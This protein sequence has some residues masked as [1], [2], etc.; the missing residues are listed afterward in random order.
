MNDYQRMIRN[1]HEEL[2]IP[3]EFA[4]TCKIPMQVEATDLVSI[5][6]DV[7]GRE[8]FLSP[9]AH[10]PWMEMQSAALASGIQLQVVSAFRSVDYQC[11]LIRNKLSRGES[12][13]EIL[14]VNAAP[15]YSEHHTGNALDLNTPGCEPLT[16]VFEETSA[17]AWLERNAHRYG[18]E[19]SYPRN[20]SYDIAYEPWHWAYRD[21]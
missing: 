3:R 12:I 21:A 13:E 5:G 4:A 19:M 7:F 11:R 6:E 9:A 17:F 14:K 10:T 8:Q 2:G 18:F 1:F 20:N 15:G 16:E